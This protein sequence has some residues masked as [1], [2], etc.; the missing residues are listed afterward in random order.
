M[1][2]IN[3]QRGEIIGKEEL[4]QWN[5]YLR[6]ALNVLMYK[7]G[8]GGNENQIGG[9]G[10]IIRNTSPLESDLLVQLGTNPV[11]GYN[12]IK[13][14]AGWCVGSISDAYKDPII[15]ST[16]ADSVNGIP[17][18]LSGIGNLGVFYKEAQDNIEIPGISGLGAGA[19]R[20]I[21]VYPR[22]TVLE[23]GTC[24]ISTSNQV[25]FTDSGVVAKLRDQTTKSPSR[26]K[27][28]TDS[29]TPY[30]SGQTYEVVTIVNSTSIVISGSFPTEVT[31]LYAAI[32][33]SY[34]FRE[35]ATLS[36]ASKYMYGYVKGLVGVSATTSDGYLGIPVAK[37]TFAADHSFTIEDMRDDYLFT[38]GLGGG[39]GGALMARNNLQDLEDTAIA[40]A[41]LDVYSKTQV[42]TALTGFYSKAQIDAAYP[43]KPIILEIGA[44]NMDTTGGKSVGHTLDISK[45]RDVR[46]LIYNDLQTSVIPL[47]S[48][49][50]SLGSPSDL[51]GAVVYMDSSVISL[52]RVENGRFDAS[53]WSSTA[54]NRGFIIVDMIA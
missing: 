15:S 21:T 34:D 18:T 31:N 30:N 14:N 50:S 44:W 24:N 37:L 41:Y 33:G 5:A 54:I 22:I 29:S 7:I 53:G 17:L 39:L 52:V 9:R 48:S 19:V 47:T 36:S 32:V 42:D 3:F 2:S 35:Q 27:F 4:I 45:V 40:R 49:N 8:W 23:N 38:L 51:A 25:T 46:V 11:G 43:L 16:V 20:Y 28:F 10:A 6:E 13:I 26:I 12:T 1:S